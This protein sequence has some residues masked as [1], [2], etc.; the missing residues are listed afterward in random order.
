MRIHFICLGNGLR[1]TM[2]EAYVRS[3]ALSG[4][5]VASSGALAD[6]YTARGMPVSEHALGVLHEHG[7]DQFAKRER[8]Q[9]TAELVHSDDMVVC[10]NQRVFAEAAAKAPLSKD[11]RVW[12]VADLGERTRV[13]HN[14]A[15]ADAAVHGMFDEIVHNTD[16]LLRDLKLT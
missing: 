7:I 10:M 1:S 12:N 13:V 15:E 4:V 6:Q 16:A 8:T 9:L 3:L 5:E 14:E 11:T 2:A